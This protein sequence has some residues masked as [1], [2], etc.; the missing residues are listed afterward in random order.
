MLADEETRSSH[1]K[2]DSSSALQ[3]N[4][5]FLSD[6]CPSFVIE[7]SFPLF[8]FFFSSMQS[9]ERVHEC[10]PAHPPDQH[11]H[12]G[13]QDGGGVAAPTPHTHT[14]TRTGWV[15]CNFIIF[16]CMIYDSPAAVRIR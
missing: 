2:A 7:L 16:A 12:A 8:F 3:G 13:L 4:V 9:D 6:F 1:L 15:I 10:P 14:H 11:D 5:A